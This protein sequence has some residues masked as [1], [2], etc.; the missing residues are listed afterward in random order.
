MNWYVFSTR[1][2]DAEETFEVCGSYIEAVFLAQSAHDTQERPKRRTKGFYELRNS[3]SE[4]GYGR[5]IAN[6][7]GMAAQGFASLVT[8]VRHMPRR[9][10]AVLPHLSR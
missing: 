10:G 6:Y 8:S 3:K 5:Y 1:P 2:E 9:R 7:K 4:H